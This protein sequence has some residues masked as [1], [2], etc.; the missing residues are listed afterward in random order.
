M[1]LVSVYTVEA[2]NDFGCAIGKAEIV[3]EDNQAIA[4][5]LLPKA[6]RVT[7]LKAQVVRNKSTLELISKY[8]G[9]PKPE[10]K[11]HKNGKEIVID[12]DVTIETDDNVSKLTITNMDRKRAGK[13]E[14]IA[15]NE[16]GESRASG[17]VM[18]SDDVTPEELKAPC[19]IEP[20][21]PKTVLLNEVVILE[22]IVESYPKSSFQWFFNANPV[23]ATA[24]IRIHAEENK[25]VLIIENF[26]IENSGI[27]TCRAENVAG[28][29][30]S[31]ASVRLVETDNQLEEIQEY[32]SPRFVKKLKPAQVMDG[33]PLQLTCRVIGHPTPKVQ[34]L[35]NKE[36]LTETRGI[37]ILQEQDGICKLNL[38]EAYP[39]NA[40]VYTCR[41]INKFGKAFTKANVTVEG[42]FNFDVHY[43]IIRAIS[44]SL[45]LY[46]TK[47]K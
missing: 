22:A 35:H 2:E 42:I 36:V 46:R 33:E 39:E 15:T 32:L 34:W 11:W 37:S 38:P 20:I 21:Q 16:A 9:N 30:T 5:K 3:L 27:Y 44:W 45:Y 29:V 40:G 24:D 1:D 25:A 10:I 26:A 47:I 14:F 12:N 31:T 41:A 28:S 19:F 6:P 4:P 23:K 8:S 17:S 43:I 13:Y 7:P 18:V